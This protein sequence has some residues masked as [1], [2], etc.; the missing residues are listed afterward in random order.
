MRV[1]LLLAMLLSVAAPARAEWQIKPFLGKTFSGSTNLFGDVDHA[2]GKAKTVVGVSTV[3]IGEIVGVEV[4]LGHAPGFFQTGRG[5]LVLK[6]RLTTLTGNVIVALPKRI[7]EYTLRPY[8]VG[9]AGLLQA[10]T[11]SSFGVLELSG[12]D[13]ALDVGGGVT[14]FV[15]RRV[16]V[17]W[18]VRHFRTFNGRTEASS[19]TDGGPQRLS[20]WRANMALAIRY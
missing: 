12:N 9:G 2:V 19:T 17:S 10:R 20:F 7:T 13:T 8:F 3:L 6:S 14:G 5:G 4:D 15:T 18:D 1:A 11:N 16:G